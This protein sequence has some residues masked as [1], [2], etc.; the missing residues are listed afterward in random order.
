MNPC[1]RILIAAVSAIS[2]AVVASAQSAP[3][4][5]LQESDLPEA[6]RAAA[7]KEIAQGKVTGIWQ[8]DQDGSVIY[9]VD[10]VVDGHARGVLINPEGVV[11]AVQDE[12]PWEKLDPG[13]QSGIQS[14]AG[15]GKVTRVVSI[16]RD[17]K[18]SR[19]VAMVEKGDQKTRVQVGPDG[20][21][22]GGSSAAPSSATTPAAPPAAAT[23][24]A[25]PPAE[26]TPGE[27]PSSR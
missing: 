12:V 10:L 19:Y 8:R 22:L 11:V 1:R 17:G 9:E 4:K 2:I 5:Q 25:A 15:D 14:Q 16:A 26:T 18:V 21:P 24:P 23:T 27:P 6:V 13:V 3:P 20:A 7:A